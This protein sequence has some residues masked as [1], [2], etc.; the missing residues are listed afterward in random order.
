MLGVTVLVAWAAGLGVLAWREYL[1]PERDRLGEAGLRVEPSN[2]YYTVA[3]GAGIIGYASSTVDT[4]VQ[5]ISVAEL[6]RVDLPMGGAAQRAEAQSR[7]VMA[8]TSG[9]LGLQSFR[10]VVAAASGRIETSG[11]W[12]GDSVFRFVVRPDGAAADTLR[13]PALRP[14]YFPTT[15]PIA[16]MLAEVPRVGREQQLRIIDPVGLGIRET[17]VR[18]AAETL[19]VVNDSAVFDQ[20]AR[21]WREAR[22]DT[23][24]AWRLESR[25][26]PV[27]P[28]GWVDAQGRLIAGQQLGMLRLERRPFEVA[29]ANWR[30]ARTAGQLAIVPSADLLETTAIAAG[31][32]VTANPTE[33]VVR[34]SGVALRG[35]QLTGPRQELRGDTLVVRREQPAALVADYRSASET[36]TRFWSETR[37][38]PLIESADPAIAALAQRVGG[39]GR[40]EEKAERLLRWVHD[41]LRKRVTFG[42]PSARQVLRSR[43]GDCNEHT[44]LYVALARARGIPA[45]IAAGFVHIDGRFYYHAWPEIWLNG[46]VAVDP[47][48]GQFPAGAGH[49]RF[50]TGGLDR[51]ADLLALIGRLRI[52]VLRQTPPTP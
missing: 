29:V 13:V 8:R 31:R 48:L 4:T 28:Q 33:L 18:I 35:F 38:E 50:V 24:R 30:A 1:D 26:E 27:M 41:S 51:Q 11:A 32:L 3:Q 17:T 34:L 7:V 45:R 15:A 5:Q 47:T 40:P 12:E 25:G 19:F 16:V 42:I 52:D 23:V 44:Q 22:P 20:S 39:I 6:V 2:L 36:R 14:V 43:S 46:W 10:L 49:L 21:T 37:P 9:A